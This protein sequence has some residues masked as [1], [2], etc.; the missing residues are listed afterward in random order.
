MIRTTMNAIKTLGRSVAVS[1]VLLC[2]LSGKLLAQQGG[3]SVSSEP[4]VAGVTF[5]FI[6][7]NGIKLRIAEAGTGP[8]VLMAHGWPE[9]W[10]SWR[11]QITMLAAAGYHVVA[12]D[13]RGYGESDKPVDVD[14]YD[15]TH[16][17]ADLV[18]ILDALGEETAILVGHDWGAIVAW[19][20]VLLHPSRFTA[21]IAM[22]VPY[23]GRVAQSPIQ[24]WRETFGENFFYILYHNEPGGVAEAEYDADPRGLISRL[25]L[26]PGAPRQPATITD[27]HRS[28][29]GWIGRLGAAKE[30][31]D[32]LRQEDLD[33]VVSQFENAG[34]RGGINYYRNFHRNWEITEHL[35]GATIKVPVLFIAGSRDSVIA[36]ADEERLTATISRAAD[37]LRGVILISE[38]GHWVQ[39]EAPDEVNQAISDF[40]TAIN[41][42]P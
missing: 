17:A 5:R 35:E 2:A 7:S 21:L 32:W 28:A 34:F 33:Y 31:P 27:A 20:T 11:H 13:M 42:N 12:P 25:Y 24:S 15:I 6:H 4:P 38:I 23:G 30:L 1:L 22:S 14:D 3:I 18:G 26:S 36:G 16:V 29:G 19:S 37:D 39:Q 9:S 40:L 10:Y 8:L 41:I